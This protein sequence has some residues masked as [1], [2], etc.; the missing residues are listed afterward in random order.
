MR[1]RRGLKNNLSIPVS[2]VKMFQKMLKENLIHPFLLKILNRSDEDLIAEEFISK[3]LSI[4][5]EAAGNSPQ[6]AIIAPTMASASLNGRIGTRKTARLTIQDGH[7][8]KQMKDT[9]HL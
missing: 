8:L 2:R 9:K 6:Y 4:I 1:K 5:D 7:P 3:E